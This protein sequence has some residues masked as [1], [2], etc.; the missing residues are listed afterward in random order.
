MI[1]TNVKWGK[2]GGSTVEPSQVIHIPVFVV[3][4]FVDSVLGFWQVYNYFLVLSLFSAQQIDNNL[5]D[6]IQVHSSGHMLP[7]FRPMFSSP[8]IIPEIQNHQS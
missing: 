7:H 1:M 8:L 5:S 6:F 3:S 2:G 4:Y